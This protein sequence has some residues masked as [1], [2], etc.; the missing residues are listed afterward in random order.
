MRLSSCKLRT[1]INRLPSSTK[2]PA[3]TVSFFFTCLERGSPV[4]KQE[5]L[6]DSFERIYVYC[7][8]DGSNHEQCSNYVEW[9]E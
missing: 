4:I 8:Y 3:N 7:G 2:V 1:R 9:R 5:D 6:G